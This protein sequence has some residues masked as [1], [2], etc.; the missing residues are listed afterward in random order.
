LTFPG[1]CRTKQTL[2]GH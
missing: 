2:N 1:T